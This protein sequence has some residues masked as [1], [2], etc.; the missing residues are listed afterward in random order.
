MP[1][2]TNA[3]DTVM[4]TIDARLKKCVFQDSSNPSTIT[5]I[6]F[7]VPGTAKTASTGWGIVRIKSVSTTTPTEDDFEFPRKTAGDAT[8]ETS[9]LC[10]ALSSRESYTYGAG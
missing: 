10:F 6:C 5:Y 7:A 1:P 9:E 4:Q 2:F 8:S 3:T